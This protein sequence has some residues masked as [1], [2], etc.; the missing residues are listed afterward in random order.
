MKTVTKAKR[1]IR[2]NPKNVTEFVS[3]Y[4]MPTMQ[5]VLKG[6]LQFQKLSQ[7]FVTE[8]KRQRPVVG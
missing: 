8:H 1:Q 7:A 5:E 4:P 6:Y 2:R 3:D